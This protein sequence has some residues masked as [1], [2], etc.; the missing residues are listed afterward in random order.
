[1]MCVL[2]EE[3]GE[4]QVARKCCE[5][6][7]RRHRGSFE[8]RQSGEPQADLREGGRPCKVT[9]GLHGD[10]NEATTMENLTAHAT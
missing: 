4:E 9:D 1:M 3:K 6:S 5:L 2:M 10:S 7:E 8:R